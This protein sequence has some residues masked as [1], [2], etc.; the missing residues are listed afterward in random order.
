MAIRNYLGIKRR[1][2][3]FSQQTLAEAAEISM[4]S[5]QS[6][7]AGERIPPLDKARRLAKLLSCHVD[8]LW[9]GASKWRGCIEDDV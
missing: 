4:G 9:P 3:G 5:L 7:E 6:Y 8:M 1:S 2:K